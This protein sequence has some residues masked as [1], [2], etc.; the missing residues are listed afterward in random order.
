MHRSTEE[1]A[2][3]LAFEAFELPPLIVLLISPFEGSRQPLWDVYI[4]TALSPYRL[5]E[6]EVTI[7]SILGPPQRGAL[8]RWYRLAQPRE[9]SPGSDTNS[10]CSFLSLD[11]LM[12]LSY[13]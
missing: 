2:T 3:S 11:S 12:S 1:V 7:N 10:Y 4:R 9:V 13:I 6:S 8:C 5:E